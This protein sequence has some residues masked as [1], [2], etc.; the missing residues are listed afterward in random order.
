MNPL[1]ILIHQHSR[2]FAGSRG[3]QRGQAMVEYLVG[4]TL[5]IALL[6]IPIDG[7]NSVVSLMLEAVR[8]AW[9]KFLAALSL[10]Q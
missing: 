8:T 7:S 1:S 3:C 9:S 4:L 2:R 10:P 5:A 6:A